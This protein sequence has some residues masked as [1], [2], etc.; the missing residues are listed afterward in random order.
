MSPRLPRSSFDLRLFCL[1][2]RL[3]RATATKSCCNWS[4]G[5]EY[6][7]NKQILSIRSFWMYWIRNSLY[8]YELEI[9]DVETLFFFFPPR[10]ILLAWL[11]HQ[12]I[13]PEAT[14][15]S[16]FSLLSLFYSFVLKVSLGKSC[17]RIFCSWC[18]YSRLAW[19]G[20]LASLL[21]KI[22]EPSFD[23]YRDRSGRVLLFCWLPSSASEASQNGWAALNSCDP[24]L[25]I[26]FS[27]GVST[28][29]IAWLNGL[30]NYCS[31]NRPRIHVTHYLI[32]YSV[33]FVS[34]IFGLLVAHS[35][36]SSRCKK[37]CYSAANI[38]RHFFLAVLE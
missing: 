9:W 13:F 7:I 22:R 12:R 18:A 31:G 26:E 8:F 11:T 3:L 4:Y 29:I 32:L 37:L 17:F 27:M 25:G 34:W 28:F 14:W 23:W 24:D 16:E 6:Q 38:D 30:I 1:T 10:K 33:W 36:S 15:S 2:S 19:V 5:E 20:S 21:W 35:I